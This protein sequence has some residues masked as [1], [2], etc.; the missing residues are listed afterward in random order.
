MIIYRFSNDEP[1]TI[2]NAKKANPQKIGEALEAVAVAN[3]GRLTPQAVVLVARDKK[4]ALHNHFEWNDE[5]AAE[6]FRRDQ[7]RSLIRAIKVDL[8][9]VAEPARAF[10]SVNEK[11]GVSYRRIEDVRGNQELQLLVLQQAERDLQAWEDRYRDLE[12][13]CAIVRTARELAADRRKSLKA[14]SEAAAQ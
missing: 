1:L 10:V 4:S 2:K 11:S 3:K 9:D 5:A 8:P 13:L 14:G 12:E 7:A 6:M